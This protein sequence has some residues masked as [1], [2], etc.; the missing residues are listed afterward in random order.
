PSPWSLLRFIEPQTYGRRIVM[1]HVTNER[2]EAAIVLLSALPA[3]RE[4]QVTFDGA[5]ETRPTWDALKAQFR[6]K[7]IL[8]V[9][10]PLEPISIGS[11]P[12]GSKRPQRWRR[13]GDKVENAGEG[14]V[15]GK[16]LIR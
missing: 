11:Y 12:K 10:A 9:A 2:V 15:S 14:H 5:R 7:L 4:V 8:P 1:A 6:D 13:F 3:L 16:K